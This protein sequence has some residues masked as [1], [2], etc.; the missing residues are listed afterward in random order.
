M[1][2][3]RNSVSLCEALYQ[4][5]HASPVLYYNKKMSASKEWSFN[6]FLRQNICNTYTERRIST[7]ILGNYGL[8]FAPSPRKE[9]LQ[10]SWNIPGT[11]VSRNPKLAVLSFH[12]TVASLSQAIWLSSAVSSSDEMSGNRHGVVY[13]TT[14]KTGKLKN[15]PRIV[16]AK[17]S[18]CLD[19]E[20][21]PLLINIMIVDWRC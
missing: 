14:E 21:I 20:W 10:P 16:R 7:L 8:H 19:D 17:A 9:D 2:V 15:I 4:I 11:S 5:L 6:F 13:S 18:Y 3:G 12:S 1:F